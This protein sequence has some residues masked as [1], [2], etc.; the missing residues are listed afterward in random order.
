MNNSIQLHHEGRYEASATSVHQKRQMASNK[1]LPYA[2]NPLHCQFTRDRMHQIG[3]SVPI[4]YCNYVQ[5]YLKY[6]ELSLPNS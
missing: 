1:G 2:T 6:A 4:I 3:L 5:K